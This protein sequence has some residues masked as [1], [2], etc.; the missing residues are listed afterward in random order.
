MSELHTALLALIV[1]DSADLNELFTEAL[2][3]SGFQTESIYDGEVAAAR[4]RELVPDLVLLDLHLPFVSGADLLE[5]IRQDGRLA[6]TQVIVA[7][8]DGTWSTYL[9]DEADFVLNKPV[10]YIQLRDL[11]ARILQ[12]LDTAGFTK[13]DAD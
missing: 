6:S 13:K 4:L 12:E 9:L 2:R 3:E 10:S 5:Q 1:E 8:A 7:S 11:A